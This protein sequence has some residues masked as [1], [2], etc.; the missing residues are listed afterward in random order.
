MLL[1]SWSSTLCTAPLCSWGLQ[2]QP[3]LG[4]A[5]AH[6]EPDSGA[7]GWRRAASEHSPQPRHQ[8]ERTPLLVRALLIAEGSSS[9]VSAV[10]AASFPYFCWGCWKRGQTPGEPGHLPGSPQPGWKQKP[11]PEQQHFQ[12]EQECAPMGAALSFLPHSLFMKTASLREQGGQ[13]HSLRWGYC[14]PPPKI[15]P[16]RLRAPASCPR[17]FPTSEVQETWPQSASVCTPARGRP[18]S[19]RRQVWHLWQHT[20]AMPEHP[21]AT[22]SHPLKAVSFHHRSR[23]GPAT[24]GDHIPGGSP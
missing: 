2:P 22:I 17:H 1:C 15:L 13:R 12:G 20:P 18:P 24:P 7:E 8:R 9:R 11:R 6:W 10:T 21:K 16:A 4:R 14:V 19:W 5:S 3:T 23:P